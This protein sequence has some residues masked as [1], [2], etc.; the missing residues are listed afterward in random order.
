MKKVTQLKT[1]EQIKQ[2]DTSVTLNLDQINEFNE[3]IG[4]ARAIVDLVAMV[5]DVEALHEQTLGW[6]LS[7]SLENLDKVYEIING[8]QYKA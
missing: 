8:E 3:K 2:G 6:A 7:I 1:I 4:K 5:N